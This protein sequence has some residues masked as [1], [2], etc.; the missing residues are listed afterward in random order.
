[1]IAVVFSAGLAVAPKVCALKSDEPVPMQSTSNSVAPATATMEWP[2]PA[3]P[4]VILGV[5]AYIWYNGCGPTAVGVVVGYRDGQGYS[6]LVPGDAS[7][8]NEYV[9]NMIASP[10]HIADYAIPYDSVWTGISPDKS[11][12]GGAHQSDCVADFMHTSWSSDGNCWG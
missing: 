2:A 11:T 8:Q 12:V 4:A 10:E 9:D 1:M 6:D 5:P 7:V 3:N